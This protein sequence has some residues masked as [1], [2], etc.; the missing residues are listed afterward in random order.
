MSS[1]WIAVKPQID[2]LLCGFANVPFGQTR[3]MALPLPILLKGDPLLLQPSRPVVWP[4]AEL[5][6]QL[7]RLHA[8]LTNFRQ[9]HGF[10]RAMSA[11]Q[12]G[13]AKR[14]IV[15]N[16]GATPLALI[17]PQLTWR[18]G[19][20]FELWDDCLSLPD[21]VVRVRRQRSISLRYDDERGRSRLWQRLPPDMAELLQH[22]L[23]HLDG[24]LMDARAEGPDAI[25]PIAQHAALVSYARPREHRLSLAQIQ[26]SSDVIAPEF[27]HSPQYHCEPLSDALGCRLMLKPETANPIRS[28]K[29]RG[30]SFLLHE[31]QRK[32]DHRALVC[33]SAGNW[34]QAM[35]YACRD[36]GRPLVI[37]AA[38]NANPLKV[39]RMKALGAK[40]IQQGHDFDAAKAAAKAHAARVG[41]WMVEDGLEAEVS[42]G[43]GSMAIELLSRGDAY[44]ALVLPLG[45]GALLNGVGH[46]IK[47]ASPATRVIGVCAQGA[48]SMAQSWHES[49]VVETDRA[50]T[51]ADGIAVRVPIAEA[52]QDMHGIVDDVLLIDDEHLREAMRLAYQ[53]AGLLLEPA[54]AAGLA[55][56]V[57]DRAQFAGQHVAATLC[58]SNLTPSQAQEYFHA[59]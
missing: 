12:A 8:T 39:Q 44:D 23:D 42:E 6:Q 49:R 40:V 38:V 9:R 16:L 34:G 14:I 47:A 21:C 54:G 24:V 11:V 55:A 33:A 26:R 43:H 50:D 51:L 3:S 32:Q 5:P 48:P 41:G 4:D 53:H 7:V 29:G 17:N 13:I 19:E 57:A 45:N 27:L 52:V 20:T 15:M 10:G 59:P 46:W 37:Y 56:L 18:S 31:L 22:E 25:R 30:A 1:R 35:A 28:F 58:G 2:G 36:Q